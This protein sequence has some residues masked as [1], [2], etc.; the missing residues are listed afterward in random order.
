[1]KSEVLPAPLRCRERILSAALDSL[2]DEGYRSSMDRIA[3]RAGVAKQT[4]YN[5]FP[6]KEA[7]Y[8]EVGHA[9]AESILEGLDDPSD[10]LRAALIRFGN[11]L[12]AAVLNERA[13]AFFRAVLAEG[14]RMPTLHC[15]VRQNSAAQL[16][17]RIGDLISAAI[18]QGLLRPIPIPFA[19][20]M[21]YA[22][23]VDRDRVK[24]MIGER[25]LSAKAE[26]QR[27][28]QIVDCFLSAFQSHHA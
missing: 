1:M 13:L 16:D 20:D 12:R 8:A 25:P 3:A 2:V 5:H 18:K 23:L 15:I 7:L 17:H 28:N 26:R 27:V 19:L 14:E 9:F 21:L 4:L 6:S 10:D 24:L 22:M 11:N